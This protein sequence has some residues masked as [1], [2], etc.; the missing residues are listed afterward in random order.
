MCEIIFFIISQG[1]F[2]RF[3]LIIKMGDFMFNKHLLINNEDGE[4]LYLFVDF[5]YEF[6]F[7]FKMKNKNEKAKALHENVEDYIKDKKIN[8]KMGK[9]FLV[10]GSLVIGSLFFNNYQYSDL[11]G[12]LAPR[13]QYNEQIDI[14]NSENYKINTSLQINVDN[15]IH[16]NEIIKD[17]ASDAIDNEQINTAPAISNA[18]QPAIS[19][20]AP[21]TSSSQTQSTVQ[22]TPSIEVVEP[23]KPTAP[24][25]ENTVPPPVVTSPTP[26]PTDQSV[27]TTAAPVVSEQMVTV[28]RYSG[29]VDTV[30]LED[31]V[32]GVV[33][34]EMPASFNG[35]ALKAQSVLARTYALKKIANNQVLSDTTSNQVYKDNNQ[36]KTLWGNEYE[37]YYNKI[38][39][40]VS[41]TKGQYLSYNGNYIEAVYHSTSNGQTE[42]SVSVWGNVYPYLNSVDSHWDVDASSFLRETSKD[43]SILSSIIGLDFNAATNIEVLSRTSGNR[44]DKIKVGDKIFTGIEFRTLFGLR[45][46]DFDIKIEGDKAVFVTRGYGHGVGMSQYGANGMA[47]EGYAYRDILSHYYPGTQI[48]N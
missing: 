28:Y 18:G 41:S 24:V 31:Y 8:F 32:I 1:I 19:P 6:S 25:T 40:V 34:S 46:A 22:K 38:K 48:K 23:A 29:V 20:S 39:N 7:D 36:L 9:V 16:E 14:L 35:E 11:K 33:S 17:N 37:T 5:D 45:S 42:D 12:Q 30:A 44:V 21:V 4:T 3:L 43:F 27:P 26:T 47:K 13:Y 2:S 15:D 10:V